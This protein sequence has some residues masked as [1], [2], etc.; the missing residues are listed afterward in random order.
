MCLLKS[1]DLLSQPINAPP[2]PEHPVA[3]EAPIIAPPLPEHHDDSIAYSESNEEMQGE[4]EAQGEIKAES[5]FEA[6]GK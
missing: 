4:I 3:P 6:Q 2:L 5:E 1:R